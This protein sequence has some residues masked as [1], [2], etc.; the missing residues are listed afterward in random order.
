MLKNMGWSPGLPLGSSKSDNNNLL[1][2]IQTVKRPNRIGL[3]YD[4]FSAKK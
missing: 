4:P 3:G 2:P 1:T